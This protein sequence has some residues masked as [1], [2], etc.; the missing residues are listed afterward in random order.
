MAADLD[1][2][3]R[4]ISEHR[5]IVDGSPALSP[6]RAVSS[7]NVVVLEEAGAFA[8]RAGAKLDGALEALG[9][10]VEGRRVLD[11]G[12]G[13]GGFTDC[14]LRRGA[15]AVVAVDVGY[16]LMDWR[17]RN[18]PRVLTM[19]RTN[20]RTVDPAALGAPF[21]LVVADLSFIRLS[22]VLHSLVGAAGE[23]GE[24]LL[25]VKPQF[26]ARRGEVGRGGVVRDPGVHKRV[27]ERVAQ[28]L[29]SRGVGV[30]G[31]VP[32]SPRGA[33][34]NQEFFVWARRG[35][36]EDAGAAI[37]QAIDLADR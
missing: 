30:A 14:L 9:I 31:I 36:D 26:E 6:A 37:A 21:D 28:V 3:R 1:E 27:L 29:I 2:A 34:G 24:L 4:A 12:A 22:A 35:G 25:L 33:E 13:S 19:E 7:N 16:G 23:Q 18:D 20:L 10:E 8:S 32:A 17:L 5:V 11:A 15:S